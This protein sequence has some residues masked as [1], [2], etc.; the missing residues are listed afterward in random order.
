MTQAHPRRTLRSV[1]LASGVLALA[2]V[3]APRLH[4]QGGGMMNM[5]PAERATQQVTQLNEKLH[6]S[7]Q[8]TEQIKA[9][10][11]KQYTDSRALREKAQAS[12]GDMQSMRPQMQA[13][14]D[15]AE[16]KIDAVLTD[17]QKPAYKAFVEE[18]R[19][20]RGGGGPRTR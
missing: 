18:Q 6:L 13:L 1:L 14:R 5:D 9:I 2:L 19:A 11:V 15:E 17:A 20:R 7:A 10:L 16:K 4:A 3:G 12:G 8:Q